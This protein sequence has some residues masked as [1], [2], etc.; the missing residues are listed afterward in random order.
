MKIVDVKSYVLESKLK[1]DQ[2]FTWAQAKV[3]SRV[4]LLVE[5]FTDEGASG[6]G[7]A[8]AQQPMRSREQSG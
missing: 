5:V 4:T 1:P 7:E 8:S 3:T 6:I 2:W